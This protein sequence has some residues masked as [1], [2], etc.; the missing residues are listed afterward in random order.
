MK[1]KTKTILQSYDCEIE[2]DFVIDYLLTSH[3][4]PLLEEKYLCKYK[5]INW[6]KVNLEVKK[7]AKKY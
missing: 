2:N 3:I 5:Y 6:T 1:T 7:D 4:C